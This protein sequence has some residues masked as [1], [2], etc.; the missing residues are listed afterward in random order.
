MRV[1]LYVLVS[2][3]LGLAFSTVWAGTLSVTVTAPTAIDAGHN[4]ILSASVT[5]SNALAYTCNWAYYANSRGPNPEY[6]FANQSCTVRFYG[7]A[8]DLGSPDDIVVTANDVYGN[9]G[10]GLA[11]MGVKPALI[12]Q[13]TPSSNT[14]SEGNSIT[15]SNATGNNTV[16][17]SGAPPYRFSY[18]IPR[19]V[20]E[21]GNNFTFPTPGTYE[22]TEE[23][24]DS[25][26]STVYA[27]V[28]ITV[29]GFTQPLAVQISAPVNTLEV[30]Q[31]ANVYA[32][33]SGGTPPYTYNWF[34]N[35]AQNAV[36]TSNT[37]TFYPSAAG[38][39]PIYANAIDSSGQTQQSQSITFMVIPALSAKMVANR[40]TIS[41]GQAVLL[42]NT[43]S[44]GA[45]GNTYVY[46]ASPLGCAMQVAG[47]NAFEFTTTSACEVNLQATDSA[48][49]QANANVTITPTVALALS[50]TP[51]R[52]V[53]SV[54]QEVSFANSSAGGTGGNK[55]AYTLSPVNCAVQV[56]EKNAF[57]FNTASSCEV[58]L[59]VIDQSGEVANANVTITPASALTEA[60]STNRTVIDENQLVS[61]TNVSTGGTGTNTYTYTTTPTGCA[62]EVSGASGADKFRFNTDAQCTVNLE[63][64]DYSQEMANSNVTITPAP[65]LAIA[66]APNRTLISA[67]QAVSLTNTTS[68]GIAPYTYAYTLGTTNAVK[69]NGNV[70]A[71]GSAGNYIIT[72]VATDSVGGTSNAVAAITVTPQLYVALSANT[73]NIVTGQSVVFSNV[74]TGGTGNNEYT[75]TVNS[76]AGVVQNGNEFAFNSV[77]NFIVTLSVIDLS[78]EISES[79]VIVTVNAPS[80][81]SN[82]DQ[83]GDFHGYNGESVNSDNKMG[84]YRGIQ[85]NDNCCNN[86]TPGNYHMPGWDLYNHV[87]G[88]GQGCYEGTPG[89]YLSNCG[90]D[91]F[92][93]NDSIGLGRCSSRWCNGVT[94]KSWSYN[95]NNMGQK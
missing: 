14:L 91:G 17:F 42:A 80:A 52:T 37:L 74:T 95:Y 87:Q 68:G 2:M 21:Q 47:K 71:F 57:A 35:G 49:I 92:A 79:N 81:C 25:T 83:V 77:G 46:T 24:Q 41:V 36:V 29:T 18:I 11:V 90:W 60:L 55:Y 48:G 73:A 13:I 22:I 66:L 20:I 19:G 16:L 69:Q 89:N 94:D 62:T 54:G 44:G 85:D 86:K 8:S 43:T 61:F 33:T 72:L 3:I 4:T 7:N 27:S 45:G 15:I 88:N 34:V 67:N 84:G 10:S 70:F 63:V 76:M 30:G 51:N 9:T 50:L 59:N 12:L 38:A 6:S 28:N 58:N 53:I 31:N 26:N 40:T 78:G 65:A 1:G 32:Q 93:W 5:G 56:T 75:Y 23:V 64:V 39:Y 82:P